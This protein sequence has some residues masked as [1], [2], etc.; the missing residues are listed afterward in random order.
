LARKGIEDEEGEELI[1]NLK[2]NNTLENV[3]LEGN[4]LGANSAK[5][6]GEWLH[7]NESLRILDL[8]ANN[9]TNGLNERRGVEQIANALKNNT[10][11]LSLNLAT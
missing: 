9:L 11:L 2:M 7:D 3:D 6:I 1:T 8:E 5:R 4:E 10:N